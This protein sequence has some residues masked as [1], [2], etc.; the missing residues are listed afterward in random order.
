MCFVNKNDL[1]EILVEGSSSGLWSHVIVVHSEQSA[2]AI[3]KCIQDQ[4]NIKTKIMT[5]TYFTKTHS[6][7]QC[8]VTPEVELL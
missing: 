3:S 4:E 6:C 8:R 5:G 7:K 1:H 2:K